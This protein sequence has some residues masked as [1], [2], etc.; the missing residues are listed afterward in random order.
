[1]YKLNPEL[2]HEAKVKISI[3]KSYKIQVKWHFSEFFLSLPS[4]KK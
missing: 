3:F 1:M 2:M 4:I